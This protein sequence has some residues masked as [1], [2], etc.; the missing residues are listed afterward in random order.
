MRSKLAA[1]EPMVKSPKEE[2]QQ[3]DIEEI[4][5]GV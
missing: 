5:I 4:Q 1:L 2:K 3:K